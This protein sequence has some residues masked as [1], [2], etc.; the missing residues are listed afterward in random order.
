MTSPPDDAPIVLV[1]NENLG[2]VQ[3]MLQ[4]YTPQEYVL[5]W[6]FPEDETYRNFAIAPE[7][8]PGRSAWKSQDDPHGPIDVLRSIVDSAETQFTPEG[9]Q[10]LYRLLIYRDLPARIGQYNFTIYVRNDLVPF[11][12]GIRYG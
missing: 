5:R 10:R 4:G 3:S 8:N 9:Q 11:F 1:A 2:A 7:L 12:N 6:W